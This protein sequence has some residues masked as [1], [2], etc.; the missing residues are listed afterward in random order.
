MVEKR[1]EDYYEDDDDEPK[2]G[3]SPLFIVFIV[4]GGFLGIPCFVGIVAAIAIPNL[5]EDRKHGNDNSAVG[6]L[7]TLNASQAFY[8][9]RNASQRYANSLAALQSDNWIDSVLG[10]GEKHGYRFEIG[11]P[12]GEAQY[13]YWAKA[14][15]VVPGETGERYLFTNQNGR[16]YYSKKDFE[17]NKESCEPPPGLLDITGR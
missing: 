5:L 1:D 14:S 2:K 10:S 16:I 8:L 7:R 9:E 4:L 12:E 17:V 6:S 3:T 13:K 11:A 15:P